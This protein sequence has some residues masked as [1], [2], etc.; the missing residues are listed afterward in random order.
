MERYLII[1]TFNQDVAH[2]SPNVKTVIKPLGS[3]SEFTCKIRFHNLR[4]TEL[5]ALLSAI[6]FHGN[7]DKF[8]HLIG[9][10]KPLDTE[11]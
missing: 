1:K 4:K 2:L 5:G 10:A 9:M 6:T 8:Y 11:S 3:D 7:H